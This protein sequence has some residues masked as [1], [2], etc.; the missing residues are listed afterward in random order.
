MY[1]FYICFDHKDVRTCYNFFYSFINNFQ[2]PRYIPLSY[3]ITLNIK[4]ILIMILKDLK[5]VI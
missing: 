3:I 1:I 2:Y 4:K 5:K